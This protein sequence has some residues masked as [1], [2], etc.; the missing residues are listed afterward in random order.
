MAPGHRIWVGDRPGDHPTVDG[1]TTGGHPGGPVAGRRGAQG[2]G[3]RDSRHRLRLCDSES[4][5][6]LAAEAV[7]KHMADKSLIEIVEFVA[8]TQLESIKALRVKLFNN[9]KTVKWVRGHRLHIEE[10]KRRQLEVQELEAQ[11]LE[12][13]DSA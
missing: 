9:I 13:M 3:L 7:A 10:D 11:Q 1:P 12:G 6:D 4:L 8:K 5:K 2:P